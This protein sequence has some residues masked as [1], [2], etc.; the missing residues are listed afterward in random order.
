MSW[1]AVGDWA[2]EMDRKVRAQRR[3]RLKIAAEYFGIDVLDVLGDHELEEKLLAKYEATGQP[4][5]PFEG[6]EEEL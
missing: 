2:A 6:E 4:W 1:W 3:Q 5:P